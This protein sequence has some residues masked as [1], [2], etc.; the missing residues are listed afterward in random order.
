MGW[1]GRVGLLAILPGLIFSCSSQ[2]NFSRTLASVRPVTQ[3]EG[4]AGILMISDSAAELIKQARE[5]GLAVRGDHVLE[6]RGDHDKINRLRVD[7]S[8]RW[9]P[10]STRLR[11]TKPTAADEPDEQ[12]YYLARKDFALPELLK[13]HPTFDGRGVLAGVIDDGVAPSGSGFQRTTEGKRKFLQHHWP[14]H[15]LDTQVK[16]IADAKTASP[17]FQ[18]VTES[19]DTAWEGVLDEASL[20]SYDGQTFDLNV[21]G[22]QTKIA[23][24]VVKKGDQTRICLDADANDKSDSDCFGS[25]KATGEYG[26]W[27]REKG[28]PVVAEFNEAEAIVRLSEGETSGDS[29]GEGV[30][31]VMVGH[32]IGGRFDGMAPGAQLMD[33][34]FSV[35]DKNFEDGF[36]TIG[37]FVRSLEWLGEQKVEVVNI[38]YSLFFESVAAQEFMATAISALVKKY[39]FVISFSAGNNGPG[40]NS[41]N[42]RSIYPDNVLVAGAFVSRE[43]DEYVHGVTGLPEQGR[44]IYYSSRGPGPDGGGGPLLL[45]PL[46]SLT[47]AGPENAF[48]AFSGTSS[49]SPALAGAAVVLISGLKQLGLPI[50][51]ETVVHALRLSG[52]PLN[53][54]AFVDQ[55][56]GLPKLPRAIEIYRQLIAGLQFIRV[57]TVVAPLKGP[58]DLAQRGAFLHAREVAEDLEVR[59]R[60]T[61]VLS[62]K[63]AAAVGENLLRPLKIEYSAPWLSGPARGW[64]S[65]GMARLGVRVNGKFLAEKMQSRPGQEFLGEVHLIDESSGLRLHTIPFTVVDDRPWDSPHRMQFNLETRDAVRVHLGADPRVAGYRIRT[66]ISDV[67]RNFLSL[68]FF[69]PMGI[70]QIPSFW[71]PAEEEEFFMPTAKTGDYQL[72]LARAVGTEA[73]FPLEIEAAPLQL[74]LAT[75]VVAQPEGSDTGKL[76]VFNHGRVGEKVRVELLRAPTPAGTVVTGLDS[77][78]DFVAEFSITEPGVYELEVNT[79]EPSDMSFG[80]TE[81]LTEFVSADLKSHKTWGLNYMI[82]KDKVG[83]KLRFVCR[84]FSHTGSDWHRTKAVG[85]LYRRPLEKAEEP[86]VASAAQVRLAPG[87]NQLDIP[88]ISKE[89]PGTRLQVVVKPV[90]GGGE[91]SLGI[92]EV[93]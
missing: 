79:V 85:Q 43:L 40:L 9:L 63:V 50:D 44:V 83:G 80:F 4:Q 90:F 67:R 92:V 25:F 69:D 76:K 2:E 93:H 82:S 28:V 56:Y 26:Y 31:S 10:A 29:H 12:V 16:L 49:A 27:R 91:I 37:S 30:A 32:Q 65:V 6:I 34:D 17:Y 88:W 77:S 45:A 57:K 19:Y 75:Q 42:R 72:T 68:E 61:G 13:N 81:C 21:D 60:V 18:T 38:S 52:Q 35:P 51:A 1:S 3:A 41:L 5:A 20:K 8:A 54:T 59:V 33:V 47:H 89:E 71:G 14:S 46:S 22:K 78:G 15:L 70:G 36:Y 11:A 24:V 73:V 87:A 86:L 66:A 39:N 74:Q 53:G 84:P 23:V 7:R 64:L 62:P 55:G 58:D 48:Q